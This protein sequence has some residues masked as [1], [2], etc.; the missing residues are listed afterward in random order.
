LSEESPNSKDQFA[1]EFQLIEDR[2]EGL[3]L[4]REGAK[5]VASAMIWTKN[6]THVIHTHLSLYSDVDRAIFVRLPKEFDLRKF[7]TALAGLGVQDCF[8]SVSLVSANIFFKSKY[9][10]HEGEEIGF[11]L[12]SAVY[13]VQR[14]QDLRFT[15]PDGYLLKA[16]FSDPALPDETV[17]V[18]VL[19]L[20]AGGLA[21]LVTA[22]Q[23][24]WFQSGTTLSQI[25]FSLNKKKIVADGEVRH[26]G[27]LPEIKRRPYPTRKETWRVGVQFRNLK[28]A[29]QQTIA[30]YVFEESRKYFTRFA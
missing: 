4:I 10:G 23:A 17:T 7:E 24:A 8:F 26:T 20:S 21:F 22:E 28:Q 15:I 27:E 6:Q 13:K 18:R 9:R 5:M 25:S 2:N 30:A 29:D 19:D 16:T 3:R 11:D 1:R 12:P 14:R